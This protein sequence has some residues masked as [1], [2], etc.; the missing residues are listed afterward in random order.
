MENLKSSNEE[1]YIN[2]EKKVLN[3]EIIIS[4]KMNQIYTEYT[5]EENLKNY[6]KY[7]IL[8]SKILDSSKVIYIPLLGLSNAGKSTIL[9]GLIGFNI[10]PAKQTEC[11]KKGILIRY[12]E[13]DY[14]VMRKTRFINE[15][16]KY[17]FQSEKEIIAKNIEDIQNILNGLN[18]KFTDNEED[19]FMK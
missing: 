5:N 7:L 1:K 12:W 6:Q 18:N 14:P 4:G 2:D 8:P 19:F 16:N 15:N 13:N 9:N 3:E 11:T 10:L 17:R